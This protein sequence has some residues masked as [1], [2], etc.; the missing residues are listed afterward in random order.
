MSF[1]KSISGAMRFITGSLTE[2]ERKRELKE[3]IELEKR[4]KEIENRIIEGMKN[5]KE[6]EGDDFSFDVLE[7][8]CNRLILPGTFSGCGHSCNP[9]TLPGALSGCGHPNLTFLET[10]FDD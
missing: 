3:L 9:H 10:I 6:S 2:E 1:V 8:D 4:N 5:A 7:G